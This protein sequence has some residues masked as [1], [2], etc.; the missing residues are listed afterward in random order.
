MKKLLSIALLFC[1]A[2]SL[3]SCSEDDGTVEEF[4]DWQTKNET[5]WSTLYTSTLQKIANGNTEVDTIRQWSKQ[6]QTSYTGSKLTY[7]PEDYIIV[8]KKVSGTGSEL[9][10]FSDSV[11]VHYQGRL[12]PSP[13][14]TSGYVFDQSWSGDYNLLTMKA[15]VLKINSVVDG[16]ATALLNM[17][18]GDRWT[19]YMPYQLGYGTS[20]SSS[21]S[22]PAYSTLI[23]DLTLSKIY[24]VGR[25]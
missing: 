17:H 10:Q 1:A 13:T 18:E 3:V 6:H 11:A 19:V 5:Y 12:I 9:P 20:T 15:S 7:S 24:K 8:E 4:A 16:F 25:K 23:F 22:I 14:Y 2:I 21:S